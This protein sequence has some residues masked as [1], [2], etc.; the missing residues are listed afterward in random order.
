MRSKSAATATADRGQMRHSAG[1]PAPGAILPPSY[2]CTHS[3]C[4]HG[5]QCQYPFPSP[6]SVAAARGPPL[7]PGGPSRPPGPGSGCLRYGSKPVQQRPSSTPTGLSTHGRKAQTEQVHPTGKQGKGEAGGMP[8]ARQYVP[9]RRQQYV[10]QAQDV[11][12]QSQLPAPRSHSGVTQD[13]KDTN[14]E[15]TSLVI[16]MRYRAR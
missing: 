9:P 2:A 4:T 12:P 13:E 14:A 10:T 15:A 16:K 8:Q 11:A 5:C 1:A 7:P 3:F 6:A